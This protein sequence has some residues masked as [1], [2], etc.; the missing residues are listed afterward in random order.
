[1]NNLLQAVTNGNMSEIKNYLK[2]YITGDPAD[3]DNSI[4]SALKQ[5][6]MKNL[7]I[8][9]QHDGATFNTS[10]SAWTQ[11]Y[12][13]DLQVDLRMN[14]SKERFMHMLEVGKLA[15]PMPVEQ[16]KVVQPKVVTKSNTYPNNS[17]QNGT[18]GKKDQTLLYMGIAGVAVVVIAVVLVK[19]LK[20]S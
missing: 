16:P 12:F 3:T 13:V 20:N 7:N 8:W 6:E 18:S 5:I 9:E 17:P 2:A 15:F 11:D 1:M 14:F 4:K 19:L 10:R